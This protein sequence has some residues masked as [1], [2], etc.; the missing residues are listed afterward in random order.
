MTR[1]KTNASP[2]ASPADKIVSLQRLLCRAL[3]DAAGLERDHV[4][5]AIKAGG[6]SLSI[7]AELKRDPTHLKSYKE[8]FRKYMPGYDQTTV[9]R[10]EKVYIAAKEN[11]GKSYATIKAAL[12]DYNLAHPTQRTRYTPPERKTVPGK[13]PDLPK[14]VSP[15]M[16]DWLASN[17]ETELV[18]FLAEP[19]VKE[20]L[21]EPLVRDMIAH[22]IDM[23]LDG[24]DK[25][26]LMTMIDTGFSQC[27]DP[28]PEPDA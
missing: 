25:T 16:G 22:I 5:A 2:D 21:T 19:V 17:K 23:V 7:K 6:I 28:D 9:L 18:R 14:G 4:K 20:A 12:Q 10:Y 1:P 26:Y 15:K 13:T 11:K 3:D 24:S 8:W 27:E